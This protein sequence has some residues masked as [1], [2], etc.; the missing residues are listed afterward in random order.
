MKEE[1]TTDEYR[2]LKPIKRRPV[3]NFA[4]ENAKKVNPNAKGKTNESLPDV[5]IRIP[6]AVSEKTNFN[7]KQ[8]LAYPITDY[9]PSLT[10]SD[11]S[12]IKT[13]KAKLLKKLEEFQVGF[14]GKQIPPIDV[15]LINGG[16]LV[17]SYV[18]TLGSITSYGNLA[19]ITPDFSLWETRKRNLCIIRHLPSDVT[20]I[21]REAAAWS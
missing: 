4:K 17:H 19:R 7:L 5:F 8:V 16:L 15:T 12:R 21:K 3:A 13:D 2:F 20:K 11:G 1:C 10:L 6:I 9:P 18:D 14:T